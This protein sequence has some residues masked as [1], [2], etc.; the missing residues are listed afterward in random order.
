MEFTDYK[1]E[2]VFLYFADK[3]IE[4]LGMK[5]DIR[6][7][8]EYQET[9]ARFRFQEYEAKIKGTVMSLRNLETD[10]IITLTLKNQKDNDTTPSFISYIIK[11]GLSVSVDKEL[12][13]I[14]YCGIIYPIVSSYNVG[15]SFVMKC[16][17]GV[18][19][20][21]TTPFRNSKWNGIP[22]SKVSLELK[23]K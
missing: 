16:D 1:N 20:L 13:R 17:V 6:E 9:N 10:N 14:L 19:E 11:E 3:K 18:L 2:T 12:K 7:I 23:E 22:I 21:S 5:W 15:S 8:K 4:Y